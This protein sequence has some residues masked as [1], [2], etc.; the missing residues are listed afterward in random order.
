ML[1]VKR[2]ESSP[3]KLVPFQTNGQIWWCDV[4]LEELGS[5]GQSVR[6]M[7]VTSFKDK[8]ARGLTATEYEEWKGRCAMGCSYAAM[9]TLA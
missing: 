5:A 6:I 4:P 2:A 1:E 9:W 7:A 3:A 8:D